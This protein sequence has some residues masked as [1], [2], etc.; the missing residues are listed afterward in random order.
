MFCKI[1]CELRIIP[2]LFCFFLYFFCFACLH[3]S[4]ISL[5]LHSSIEKTICDCSDL[6]A[7]GCLGNGRMLLRRATERIPKGSQ[8]SGN[9]GTDSMFRR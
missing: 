4:V 9:S 3:P 5:M 8:R 6:L 7:K 2:V 1:H